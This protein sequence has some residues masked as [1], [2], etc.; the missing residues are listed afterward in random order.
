MSGDKSRGTKERERMGRGSQ[1][2]MRMREWKKG[3]QERGETDGGEE[4]EGA[5]LGI[6]L[7][8]EIIWQEMKKGGDEERNGADEQTAKMNADEDWGWRDK[9]E[10]G[11]GGGEAGENSEG[12]LKYLRCH[13]CWRMTPPLCNNRNGDS[14]GCLASQNIACTIYS[15]MWLFPRRF[16]LVWGWLSTWRG[17]RRGATCRRRGRLTPQRKEAN[18]VKLKLGNLKRYRECFQNPLDLCHDSSE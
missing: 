5:G 10:T 11:G 4:G 17:G 2:S 8:S 7:V 18:S 13:L 14:V 16:H 3:N 9:R 6:K 15:Q 12:W 1:M